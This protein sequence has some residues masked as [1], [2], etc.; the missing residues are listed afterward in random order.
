MESDQ[1]S[2]V[3]ENRKLIGNKWVFK[4]KRDGRFRS[5]LVILGYTQIPGTDFTDSFSPVVSNIVLRVMLIVWM[6]YDLQVDQIDVETAFLEGELKPS[7]YI[8]EMS[9]WIEIK[10]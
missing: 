8:Y 6:V 9:S 3:P 1:K 7:E 4:I 5:R 10:A 2:E